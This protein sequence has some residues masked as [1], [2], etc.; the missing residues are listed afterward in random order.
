MQTNRPLDPCPPFT[1]PLA[2]GPQ[3]VHTISF[4]CSPALRSAVAGK[5]WMPRLEKQLS[6]PQGPRIGAGLVQLLADWAVVYG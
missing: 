2:A 4:N 6:K 5:Q 1:S 3:L